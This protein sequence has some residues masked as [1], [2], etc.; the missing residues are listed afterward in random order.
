MKHKR[1]RTAVSLSPKRLFLLGSIALV[2]VGAA[3]FALQPQAEES[4]RIGELPQ[5]THVHGI[6]VD[7][8]DPS[9]IYLATH[10][11]LF[12]VSA[13]GT[14]TRLSDVQDFMGFTPHPTNPEVLYASGH[15]A[16]GGN[17]GFI[18]STDQGRT[19]TQISPGVNG[20]VDFHQMDAS[21]AE[22]DVIYGAYGGGLQ[23]SRDAGRSWEL[24]GPAP[25]KL[26]DIAASAAN[27][28]RVYAATETGLLVSS[29][30]GKT[31]EPLLPD[32]PVSMV[33]V[34]PD[35]ALYAFVIGRGLV[36]AEEP[37]VNM[38]TIADDFGQGYILHL[39]ADPTNPDRFFAV[40]GDGQVLASTDRGQSWAGFGGSGS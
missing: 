35:G 3:A 29:D 9:R 14:A 16:S 31:W 12:D 15:P 17:L 20:P 23:V 26:I 39:A 21:P 18:A 34:T 11:G 28:D 1:A 30:A 5:R 19:W 8:K 32:A 38:K 2:A 4:M 10:H 24:V 22:P 33:E 25:R 6:A 27:A 40:T 36:R 7:A 37:P 13:D